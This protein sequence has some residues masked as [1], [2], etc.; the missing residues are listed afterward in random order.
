MTIAALLSSVA[1]AF[2]IG[3]VVVGRR[4]PIVTMLGV[5]FAAMS[6]AGVERAG[7]PGWLLIAAYALFAVALAVALI[8]IGARQGRSIAVSGIG[9]LVGLGLVGLGL[10]VDAKAIALGA[11]ALTAASFVGLVV[12]LMSNE[13]RS[14]GQ[15]PT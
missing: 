2:A 1:L 10:S 7:T 12:A 3:V 15:A 6:V 11:M 14:G 9:S 4:D 5:V 8:T 13:F